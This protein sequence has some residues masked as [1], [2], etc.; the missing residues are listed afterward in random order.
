MDPKLHDQ[1]CE[2]LTAVTAEIE[3]LLGTEDDPRVEEL[4]DEDR[5]K[6][7]TLESEAA[8]LQTAIEQ[9]KK[10][11]SD[12]ARLDRQKARK[13][14]LENAATDPPPV[15]LA[16]REPLDSVRPPKLT[17]PR[18][19]GRLT[20]FTGPNAQENAYRSGMWFLARIGG[21]D[22]ATQW[23]REHGV[24]GYA[25]LANVNIEARDRE[26]GYLVPEEFSNALI[27]LQEM[28]G[29]F[30]QEANMVPMASDTLTVPRSVG[31]L[32][33]YSPDELTATTATNPTF[34]NVRLTTRT[35]STISV[36][37]RDLSEDAVINIAD[38]IAK[39]AAQALSLA[40]DNMGFIGTGTST[41]FGAQGITTCMAAGSVYTAITGNTAFNTLDLADFHGMVGQLPEYAQAGAKWFISRAGWAD[42]MVRLMDAAGGNTGAMLAGGVPLQFMGYPVVIVQVMNSTLTAQ[43]STTG[44]LALAN[45]PMAAMLGVRRGIMAETS[46]DRYFELRQ[47]ATLVS[48]RVAVNVHERGTASAAG[49]CIILTTPAS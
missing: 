44:L 47:V 6:L 41:Y 49:A 7:D 20:A 32:T 5:E 45:L 11:V 28:Y 46:T 30:R 36:F 48:E 8:E 16:P 37:S 33:V 17:F 18:Y 40:E 25:K 29:V 43:T 12:K 38:F 3:A 31:G 10:T 24:G 19:S 21:D 4:T 35:L 23:C 15:S 14:A 1:N 13:A 9:H 34:D 22:Y 39:E 2:R 42:S 26:G 27:D